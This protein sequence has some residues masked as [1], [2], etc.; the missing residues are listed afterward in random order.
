MTSNIGV[1]FDF[2]DTLAPDSTTFLL[3]EYD[4]DPTT[5][6]H[7]QFPARVQDGYDPTV[8]YL[9]LLLEQIGTE[10]PM[11]AV[12]PADLKRCATALEKNLYPGVPDIFDALDAIIA[13]YDGVGIEYFVVSEG[14]ESLISGSIISDHCS[15][16]YASRLAT[17]DSDVF[18][19]IKRPISFTDKTRYLYEINKGISAS[20]ARENP[21]AVN[22]EI[23]EAERKIPFEQMI[24]IGDGITDIPCFSLIQ[25]RGGRV[26]GVDEAD[27]TSAKQQAILDLG[28]PQRAGNLN[29]P[30]YTADGQLGSLLR[31]AVESLCTDS[32][33]NRLEAL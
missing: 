10:K 26:F 22:E 25:D 20:A 29:S 7:E 5:F 31:L 33:I 19:G 1:V 14:I 2:D 11:G 24:Y 28:S 8:A 12:T 23:D 32:T 16:I 15:E 9:T 4:I 21:Y 3:E 30:D 6:W 18:S 27:T 13:E 17:D